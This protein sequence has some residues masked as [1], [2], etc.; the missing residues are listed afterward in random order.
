MT[1]RTVSPPFLPEAPIYDDILSDGKLTDPWMNWF[2]SI[3]RVTGYAITHARF[4]NAAVL[5]GVTPG[6]E[7]PIIEVTSLSENQR[8]SLAKPRNGSII[9]NTDTNEFNF[10]QNDIPPA[11]WVTFA[12]IG[13]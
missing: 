6:D 1:N 11:R 12:P 7:T 2:N 4:S 5:P 9:Y 3:T 10:R 13:A 8:D